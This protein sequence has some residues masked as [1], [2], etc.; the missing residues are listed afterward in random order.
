MTKFIDQ[1]E[2]TCE[3][4]GGPLY[5]LGHLGP[6]T[7]LRCRCCGMDFMLDHPKRSR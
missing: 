3:L 5:L 1:L 2:P 6:T 7:W 4:C